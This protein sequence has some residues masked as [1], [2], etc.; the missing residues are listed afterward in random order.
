MITSPHECTELPANKKR[1][2]L[3]TWACTEPRELTHPSPV[4]NRKI[5]II[6]FYNQQKKCLIT[7]HGAI[8]STHVAEIE[9]LNPRGVQGFSVQSNSFPSRSMLLLWLLLFLTRTEESRNVYV[10]KTLKFIVQEP[11]MAKNSSPSR[12]PKN[13]AQRQCELTER[14]KCRISLRKTPIRDL[15]H[16]RLIIRSSELQQVVVVTQTFITKMTCTSTI[17]SAREIVGVSMIS[18]TNQVKTAWCV[19]IESRSQ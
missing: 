17:S 14:E 18:S 7:Q 8:S 1:A 9:Q 13:G 6:T 4:L 5:P 10:D 12:A 15:F 19:Q 2:H 16:L 3:E 11:S